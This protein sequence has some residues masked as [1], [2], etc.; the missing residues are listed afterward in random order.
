MWTARIEFKPDMSEQVQNLCWWIACRDWLWDMQ[1]A[2][3]AEPTYQICFRPSP[4]W[5][6]SALGVEQA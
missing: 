1:Q 3:V 5:M 2:M 4:A 6:H